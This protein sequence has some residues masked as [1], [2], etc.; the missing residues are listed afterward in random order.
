MYLSLPKTAFFKQR[1]LYLSK[2]G[3][4]KPPLFDNA[5]EILTY[6]LE[7]FLFAKQAFSPL[8]PYTAEKFL[9]RKEREC[10]KLLEEKG[11][12]GLSPFPDNYLHWLTQRET[13][14]SA[15]EIFTRWEGLWS[16]CFSPMLEKWGKK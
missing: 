10:S 13:A 1:N 9:T 16:R 2:E 8:L 11:Y 3:I 14:P 5:E 15:S 7:Y 12:A 6:Y 4:V